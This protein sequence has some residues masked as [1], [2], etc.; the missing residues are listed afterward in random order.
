MQGLS[1]SPVAPSMVAQSVSSDGVTGGADAAV[2]AEGGGLG[3][4]GAILAG[5]LKG[6]ASAKNGEDVSLLVAAADKVK[7]GPGLKDEAD[8]ELAVV[9]LTDLLGAAGIVM[10][11]V[12][13]AQQL[14][15]QG[16][17]GG[18]RGMCGVVQGDLLVQASANNASVNP[19]RLDLGEGALLA[20]DEKT[21]MVRGGEEIAGGGKLLPAH[22]QLVQVPEG[23]GVNAAELNDF[24]SRL[25]DVVGGGGAT[26]DPALAT[27]VAPLPQ[28]VAANTGP[29]RQASELSVAVPVD[30]AAWGEALGD[31]VV[32]LSG[33][34]SQVA[35]L[36]LDPPHLGPLEVR[37]TVTND[38]ASAVFV[39]HHSAVREA[40]EAAMPRLRDMLADSGIM[41]GNT[42][43]GA[44][45]FAQQQQ[46]LAQGSGDSRGSRSE[47]EGGGVAAGA[48]VS[49]QSSGSALAGRG[50]VDT[51]V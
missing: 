2:A 35:E 7:G 46:S 16:E 18:G 17:A 11:P 33:Q 31:K 24:S 3:L 40:I 39:S 45:S 49:G 20:A 41:L 6:K 4:F 9:S 48:I 14:G 42:M 34:G 1:I 28:Q 51:F 43:V 38:Q 26:L 10:A 25:D 15:M 8:G 19:G 27:I 44:E 23:T 13:Y 50:L 29:V 36:R 21:G 12:V 37:I 5:Q 30:S 47:E 32:W 22:E